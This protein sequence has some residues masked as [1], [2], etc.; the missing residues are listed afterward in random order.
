MITKTV[1]SHLIAST[2][3]LT[4]CPYSLLIPFLSYLLFSSPIT[5]NSILYLQDL[6]LSYFN[7]PLPKEKSRRNSVELWL[8]DNYH[9]LQD[10]ISQKSAV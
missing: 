7:L 3:L 1:A 4:I 6:T 5:H 10:M 2:I 8:A 9:I